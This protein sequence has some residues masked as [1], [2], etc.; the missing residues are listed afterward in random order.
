MAQVLQGETEQALSQPCV[1]VG[2]L[3]TAL[4]N[5]MNAWNLPVGN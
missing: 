1:Q 2:G 3:D 4:G 5:E